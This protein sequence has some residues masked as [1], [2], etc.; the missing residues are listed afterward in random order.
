MLVGVLL[1]AGAS[2]R[3]GRDKALLERGGESYLMR[4]VRTL[5][6][7]CDCVV[8]VLGAHAA[9]VRAATEAEFAGRI[10][11]GR[12]S[13]PGGPRRA[14][15][16]RPLVVRFVENAAWRSGMLSSARLGLRSAARLAPDGV[17]VLPVDHPAVGGATVSALAG[18]LRGA[19]AA[20]RPRELAQF[21]YALIPRHRGRRGH[22]LAMT[23]ALA[24]E[25]ARDRGAADLSDAV[26]RS[27][28]LVGY[29]D[30]ADA[31]ITFNHNA[32]R[33]TRVRGGRRGRGT[34]V[35]SRVAR[36]RAR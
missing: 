26:R 30:V 20:C 7:A 29:L 18:V 6:T 10:A 4:G 24:R 9:R 35:R 32:P 36:A 3:M 13:A 31:G 19:T 25:V 23:A 28:R 15:A 1:A 2:R 27:A 21:R 12:R 5:W 34:T 17:L 16:A 14:R 11:R 22:P 8:V 33:V